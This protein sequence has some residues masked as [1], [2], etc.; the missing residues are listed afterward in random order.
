MIFSGKIPN[1]LY[2]YVLEKYWEDFAFKTGY[3]EHKEQFELILAPKPH[4]E[5]STLSKRLT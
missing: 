5:K 3:F 4:H 2:I 1:I